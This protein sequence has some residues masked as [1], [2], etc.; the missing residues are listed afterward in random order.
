M[1][2]ARRPEMYKRI[3]DNVRNAC[4]N[5]PTKNLGEV[6]AN[7]KPRIEK[8]YLLDNK[9]KIDLSKIHFLEEY[10]ASLLN[11]YNGTFT[12]S[13]KVMNSV[14]EVSKYWSQYCKKYTETELIIL[15]IAQLAVCHSV[16]LKQKDLAPDVELKEVTTIIST[17][18]YAKGDVIYRRY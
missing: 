12:I 9:E 14:I 6:I 3:A 7:L 18:S 4:L 8:P 10:I 17:A 16:V 11:S 15:C 2:V 1:T 13:E 5:F